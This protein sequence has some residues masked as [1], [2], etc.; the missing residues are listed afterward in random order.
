M[1]GY[2]R[3]ISERYYDYDEMKYQYRWFWEVVITDNINKYNKK[4]RTRLFKEL[5]GD[6]FDWYWLITE[7]T[8]D[9]Y[10]TINKIYRWE[11]KE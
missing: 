7:H 10:P 1:I 9:M 6:L 3:K 5:E 2:G 11:V 4:K 8:G